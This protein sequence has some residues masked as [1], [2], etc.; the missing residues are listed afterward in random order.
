MPGQAL[1]KK[2]TN[3]GCIKLL[4]NERQLKIKYPYAWLKKRESTGLF[5]MPIFVYP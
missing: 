2:S 1:F 5:V 4:Q 3:M